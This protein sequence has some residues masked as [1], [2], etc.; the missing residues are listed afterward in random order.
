MQPIFSR[1]IDFNKIAFLNWC[2]ESGEDIR[3]MLNLAEGYLDSSIALAKHC[4][5]DNDDKKAD[6]LIFPIL[7]NANHCIELYLKAMTW[8]LNKLLNI[9][10]K[11]EGGHNIKQIFQTVRSKIKVYNGKE[12]QNII[13]RYVY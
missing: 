7:T 5:D 2:I 13:H 10:K 1:N 3:N 12:T 11:I 9:E 4:L 8:T 6:I